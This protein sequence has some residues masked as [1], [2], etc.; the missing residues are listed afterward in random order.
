MEKRIDCPLRT[1]EWQLR[2]PS[3]DVSPHALASVFGVGV[4][5]SVAYGRSVQQ[6][7]DALRAHFGAHKLEEWVRE[8]T[9]LKDEARPAN[10]NAVLLAGRHLDPAEGVMRPGH[11]VTESDTAALR[12][13]LGAV[14]A[15]LR[16]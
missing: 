16:S 3:P 2:V 15:L 4:M 14:S 1:C 5:A 6:T 10:A 12:T 9:N 7:E 11:V 13:V 8:I